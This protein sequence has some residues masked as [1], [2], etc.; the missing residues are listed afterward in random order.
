MLARL[1][2]GLTDEGCRVVRAVPG[3]ERA[4][5]DDALGP[6]LVYDDRPSLA[7]TSLRAGALL[8]KSARFG[9]TPSGHDDRPVD[10]VHAFG[11][12]CW[13]TARALAEA[14]GAV[15]ALEVWSHDAMSAAHRLDAAH[16]K[17]ERFPRERFVWL[18]PDSAM[19]GALRSSMPSANVRLTPWGVHVPG[20]V[21]AFSRAAESITA[22]LVGSGRQTSACLAAIGALGRL[23][24]AFPQLFIFVD[25]AFV[26][27]S[28]SIWKAAD[29]GR[30][31]QR[32]SVIEN[33]EGRREPALRADLL[34][35]PEAR[36]ERRTILLDSMAAGMA[37]VAREDPNADAPVDGQTGVI[38]PGGSG[39]AWE[40]SLRRLLADLDGAR[41][42]GLRAREFIRSERL[43]SAHLRAVLNAYVAGVA[44]AAS[45]A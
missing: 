32:F 22:V 3:D 31:L 8:Q 4:E 37:V 14:S 7:P 21:A 24:D 1:Q 23:V 33:L 19:D 13:R 39:P 25:D 29:H 27:A 36:G 42:M 38:V 16:R 44:M 26:Q 35:Q 30:L 45:T 10:V 11:D 20:E 43:A 15:L 18:A 40:S 34:I 5:V 6:M 28:H 17:D 12:G 9:L 2:V 41:A